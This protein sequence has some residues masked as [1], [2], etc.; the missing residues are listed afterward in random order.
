MTMAYRRAK[1]NTYYSAGDDLDRIQ[2]RLV[3]SS[4]SLNF[5]W[6]FARWY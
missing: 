5:S 1:S 6:A 3:Q 4:S 2:E